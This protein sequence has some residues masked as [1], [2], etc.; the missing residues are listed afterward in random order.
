ME[1][2]SSWKTIEDTQHGEK[3]KNSNRV[4][5][6]TKNTQIPGELEKNLDQIK[7]AAPKK[8]HAFQF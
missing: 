2:H 3:E 8:L 7:I 1:S 4:K 5:D 6:T